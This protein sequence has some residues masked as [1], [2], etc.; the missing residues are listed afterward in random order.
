MLVHVAELAPNDKVLAVVGAGPLEDFA[1]GCGEYRRGFMVVGLELP[2]IENDPVAD[3]DRLQWVERQAATSEKFRKALANVCVRNNAR[4]RDGSRASSAQPASSSAEPSCTSEPD[5]TAAMEPWSRERQGKLDELEIESELLRGNP[6]G[7]PHVRPLWVYLPPAYETEP[8]R[9]FPTIYLI[10]GMTG[11][12]DMW[13]NRSAF[14]PSTPENIDRLFGE[15]GCP[16]AIVV[17]ADCWTSYGG[18]QFI[19]SPG[20]GRYLGYLCDEVVPFVDSRYR[21][22]AA[23]GTA[24]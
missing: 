6:L 11:Q 12:L 7:D 19:D 8:E 17:F 23:P 4:S 20:T 15:E 1:M 3:E 13:A 10:Q 9:R 18:S 22:L 5:R 16:P 14:R 24:A 2:E 21:T